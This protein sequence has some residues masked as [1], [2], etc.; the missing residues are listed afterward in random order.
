MFAVYSAQSDFD[1]PLTGLRTGERPEPSTPA[2]WVDVTIQAASINW[3]DLWTLRGFGMWPVEPP[4]VLG[5]EGAGVLSDAT[6]VIIYPVM[7]SK[8]RPY[9][10]TLRP[11]SSRP[12]PWGRSRQPNRAPTGAD[13]RTES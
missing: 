9:P 2:G 13:R 7:G 4:V 6:D 1:E 8:D 5:T 3:H 10:L 11:H 12:R